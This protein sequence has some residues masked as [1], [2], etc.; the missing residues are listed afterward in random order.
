LKVD[1]KKQLMVQAK[2]HRE[3]GEPLRI[4]EIASI[5][6]SIQSK[7]FEAHQAHEELTFVG[8]TNGAQ[9]L[10][11]NDKSFGGEG[12]LY[13]T[14]EHDCCIPL[15]MLKTHHHRLESTTELRSH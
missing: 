15:Y 3:M 13:K 8:Y 1:I 7:N 11:A 4:E 5:A 9:I 14:S 6:E 10:Y 2:T 12:A